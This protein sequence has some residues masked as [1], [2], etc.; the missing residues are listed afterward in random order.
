VAASVHASN[1]PN[2]FARCNLAIAISL[3]QRLDQRPRTDLLEIAGDDTLAFR[4]AVSDRYEG[5]VAGT[6]RGE[7]LLHLI[8]LADD[9][10]V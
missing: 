7:T 6:R 3:D 5:A 9:Q 2:C 1:Q 10:E 8:S 4:D